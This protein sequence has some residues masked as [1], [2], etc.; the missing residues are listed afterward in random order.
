[1]KQTI[2]VLFA[3]GL[4]AGV[5]G[6]SSYQ[7]RSQMDA[8]NVSWVQGDYL[9][10]VEAMEPKPSLTGKKKA[11]DKQLLELLH[12]A[13]AH[14]M[15]GDHTTAIALYDQAETGMKLDDTS[16][17][18]TDLLEGG[19]A[20]LVND[21]ERDY[22]P[23]LAETVLVNT[24]KGLSFLQQGN[25]DLARI[26]FNRADDRTRRAVETFAAEIATQRDALEQE[27][28]KQQSQQRSQQQS[29]QQSLASDALQQSV[30]AHY[31]EP[32]Q[33]S[34]Y[35]EFIV[36]SATYLHGLFFL[37]SGESGDLE[38]ATVSLKRVAAMSPGNQALAADAEMA[39][40]LAAG[41]QSRDTID[42]RVWVMYENGLGPVAK[43][44]RFD[45]PL[46]LLH[47]NTTSPA[48]TGIALPRYADR[49]P[50]IEP[51]QLV[52]DLGARYLPESFSP[53]GKV[54]RTEMQARFPAVL[55]RAVASAA[56][57]A[58][59]QNAA[60]EELGAMG[61]LGSALFAAATT[62]ADLRSW[63][64]IPDHW[65]VTSL[66]RPESG[67]LTLEGYNGQQGDIQLPEWP[68]TLVYI[69]RPSQQGP[70]QVSLIDLEGRHGG[71]H[72]SVFGS[73]N[74]DDLIADAT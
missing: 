2:K 6:C 48:Y 72:L 73:S 34:V 28:G 10:A 51:L 23:M 15:A 44:T 9:G 58:L 36:P 26:E 12:Q 24:Y 63:Q 22:T 17:L 25:R 46:L 71:E 35:P 54:V 56:I 13:E 50:V 20:V 45:V 7:Q 59:M 32:S 11:E 33:W 14:R 57:K 62:Q 5:S 16:G 31:G 8:F 38:K 70:A 49:E 52:D 1:M 65:E 67:R 53:M 3:I 27:K 30:A 69:K 29:I 21:A 68:Y 74:A 42:H 4:V 41:R 47:G 61:Q 37:A 40:A 43:E 55:G 18:A 66:P 64:A 60:A 19:M 39:E